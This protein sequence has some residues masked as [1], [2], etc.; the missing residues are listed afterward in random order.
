METTGYSN[1]R[2]GTLLLIFQENL[3]KNAR[4][5]IR[6]QRK[7]SRRSQGPSGFLRTRATTR[8]FDADADR[9]TIVEHLPDD[10]DLWRVPAMDRSS[11]SGPARYMMS[12]PSPAPPPMDRGYKLRWVWDGEL[13]GSCGAIVPNFEGAFSR[14]CGADAVRCGS[15]DA[16][17]RRPCR[18]PLLVKCLDVRQKA[19]TSLHPRSFGEFEWSARVGLEETPSPL[20]EAVARGRR[21]LD[22]G[23]AGRAAFFEYCVDRGSCEKGRM[24]LCSRRLILNSRPKRTILKLLDDALR[25]A[26]GRTQKAAAR[27]A[28]SKQTTT[29]LYLISIPCFA[30]ALVPGSAHVHPVPREPGIKLIVYQSMAIH[31]TNTQRIMTNTP[32]LPSSGILS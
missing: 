25:G 9:D 16:R 18:R 7:E 10:A 32:T 29:D 28:S 3:E 30:P 13:C 6:R 23:S 4:R 27:G 12:G 11:Q 2:S 24:F 22:Y 8:S 14:T 21:F 31:W 20:R 17:V 5:T 1:A 15:T 19:T 26:S